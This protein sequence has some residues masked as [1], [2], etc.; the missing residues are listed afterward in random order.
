[1]FSQVYRDSSIKRRIIKVILILFL[2]FLLFSIS[3][4]AL[5]WGLNVCPF[6]FAKFE[7]F[8][9]IP[10][11]Y[12]YQTPEGF[13]KVLTGELILGGCR[14]GYIRSV[15]PYCKLPAALKL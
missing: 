10:V 14:D 9:A 3:V 11:V 13:I 1:M 12:G 8:K 5:H 6:H 7:K 2:A 15:C 4:I